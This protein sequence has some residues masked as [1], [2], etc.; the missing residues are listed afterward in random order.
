MKKYLFIFICVGI[1]LNA[2]WIDKTKEVFDNTK[3]ALLNN[4]QTEE[5]KKES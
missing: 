2:D 3:E 1:T 5:E 4:D